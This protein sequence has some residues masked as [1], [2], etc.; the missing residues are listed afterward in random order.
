[1]NRLPD[2]LPALYRAALG[3]LVGRFAR[4]REEGVKADVFAAV[5]AKALCYGALCG[6]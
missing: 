1:M 5:G 3:E 2:A 6:S 4:E